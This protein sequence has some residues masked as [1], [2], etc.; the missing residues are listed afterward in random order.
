ML[1][2]GNEKC[3]SLDALLEEVWKTLENS[4][5]MSGKVLIKADPK[6]IEVQRADMNTIER[7][8]ARV[9]ATEDREDLFVQSAIA[10]GYVNAMQ[11]HG[12]I[13]EGELK[14][15]NALIGTIAERRLAEVERLKHRKFLR[16]LRHFG[17][18][19]A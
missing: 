6:M 9:K 2:V 1:F 13:E 18:V 4:Q 7:L 15:L 12:I 3:A 16:T 14:Q 8:I 10:V 5:R 11:A 19:E 17:K